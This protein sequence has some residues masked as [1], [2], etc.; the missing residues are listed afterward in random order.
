MHMLRILQPGEGVPVTSEAS[1]SPAAGQA[2][3]R[4][5][6]TFPTGLELP[7]VPVRTWGP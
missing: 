1:G 6:P 4:N 3:S 5:H 7:V 2:G